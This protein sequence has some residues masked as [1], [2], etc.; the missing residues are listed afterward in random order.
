[1][2]IYIWYIY[3]CICI[4]SRICVC[5]YLYMFP[6]KH[7]TEPHEQTITTPLRQTKT[8]KPPTPW[9]Q[10]DFSD[11]NHL[12]RRKRG[13][14]TC[15]ESWP[16]SRSTWR[17]CIAP[18][19]ARMGPWR[20]GVGRKTRKNT[21][22]KLWN[23]VVYHQ[24]QYYEDVYPIWHHMSCSLLHFC[25]C[26]LKNMMISIMSSYI[27]IIV[28]GFSMFVWLPVFRILATCVYVCP[29]SGCPA[30]P[31][32]IRHAVEHFRSLVGRVAADRPMKYWSTNKLKYSYGHLLVITGY[33]WDYTFYKCGFLSTYNW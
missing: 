33:K 4:Y 12:G 21:H 13:T 31:A 32:R 9:D 8:T 15:C 6:P 11:V 17:R 2:C 25:L 16:W 7:R 10:D 14:S 22:S 30:R 18:Y 3:H 29:I 24:F 1:M 27:P 19:K 23:P 26:A 28:T 5:T 20:L